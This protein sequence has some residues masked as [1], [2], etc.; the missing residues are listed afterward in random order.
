MDELRSVGPVNPSL[1]TS[2]DGYGRGASPSS[3]DHPRVRLQF[4]RLLQ[5]EA[6]I[7][8]RTSVADL[9]GFVRRVEHAARGAL[10]MSVKSYRVTV[11]FAC[12]PN[13]HRSKLTPIGEAERELVQRLEA[14]LAA[15]RPLEASGE[16]R[17]EIEFAVNS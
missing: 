2:P 14:S 15:T 8:R 4:V 10:G 16:V 11:E 3:G 17:F 5:P 6:E 9:S 7:A 12:G 13:G 1:G